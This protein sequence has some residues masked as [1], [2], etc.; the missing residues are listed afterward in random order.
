MLDTTSIHS[1]TVSQITKSQ[2]SLVIFY[3]VKGTLTMD[4][5]A[6]DF[7]FIEAYFK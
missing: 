6:I 5:S 4:M 2:V 1:F 3:G 7:G